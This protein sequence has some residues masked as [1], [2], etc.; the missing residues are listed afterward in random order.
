MP[1]AAG[2]RAAGLR[3]QP[4]EAEDQRIRGRTYRAL[5]GLVCG[6]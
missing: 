2:A 5:P 6:V 1:L 4:A 3:P